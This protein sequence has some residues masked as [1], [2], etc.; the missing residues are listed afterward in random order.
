MYQ[1]AYKDAVMGYK[2]ACWALWWAMLVGV[3]GYLFT[4]L[5]SAYSLLP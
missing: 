2:W 1:K 5:G 3:G 4:L